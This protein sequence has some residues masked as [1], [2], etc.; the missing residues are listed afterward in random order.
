MLTVLL[1]TGVASALIADWLAP[2]SLEPY[3]PHYYNEALQVTSPTVAEKWYWLTF[4]LGMTIAILGF[5]VTAVS[6]DRIST[7][8]RARWVVMSLSTVLV[9]LVVMGMV[10]LL[11]MSDFVSIGFLGALPGIFCIWAVGSRGPR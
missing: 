2:M 4:V 7:N 5:T 10:G 6:L 8:V 9:C 3:H 11:P 1:I